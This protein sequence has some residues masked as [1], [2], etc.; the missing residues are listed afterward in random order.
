MR[1][2]SLDLHWPVVL[3]IL[4]WILNEDYSMNNLGADVA[5]AE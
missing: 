4:R 3:G 2:R 5:G 1:F